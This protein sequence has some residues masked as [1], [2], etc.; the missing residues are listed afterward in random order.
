MSSRSSRRKLSAAV[1]GAGRAPKPGTRTK[2]C[3]ARKATAA[4]CA[5]PGQRE[6]ACDECRGSGPAASCQGRS[7]APGPRSRGDDSERNA[8]VEAARADSPARSIATK[9]N[10]AA[11]TARTIAS[12]ISGSSARGISSRASSIRATS[13]WWRT[14]QHAEARGRASAVSALLDGAQ[15][16][17]RHFVIVGNARREAR[18][19][20]LVPRRQPGALRQR[21][22]LRLGQARPRRA[23]CARPAR[24][25]PGG[26]GR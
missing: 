7:P 13:S 14:R 15:L 3:A 26:P 8:L 10:P 22:D 9:R 17:G 11:F 6:Q 20:G 23:G 24:A 12:A 16:R 19:R 5:T 2:R 25:P 4:H 18:R 1:A 21:A